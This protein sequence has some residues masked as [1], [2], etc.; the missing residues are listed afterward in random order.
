MKK[1]L[2]C[3]LASVL[4]ISPGILQAKGSHMTIQATVQS[5]TVV[6]ESLEIVFSG[7]MSHVSGDGSNEDQWGFSA[8]VKETKLVIPNRQLAYFFT[9]GSE[10]LKTH[11]LKDDFEMGSKIYGRKGNVIFITAYSPVIHF[12]ETITQITSGSVCLSILADTMSNTETNL[13]PEKTE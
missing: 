3:T 13:T 6:G 2:K 1:L 9:K 11:N 5:F 7:T 4:L 10:P 12:E 8:R